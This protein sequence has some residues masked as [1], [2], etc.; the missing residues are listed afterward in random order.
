MS[1]EPV[2]FRPDPRRPLAA[3]AVRLTL[4]RFVEGWRALPGAARRRWFGTLGAGLVVS[5]AV[6]LGLDVWAM[7]L[8][9]AGRLAW[10]ADALRRIEA[11]SP[12]SFAQSLWGEAPGNAV[13]LIPLVLLVAAACAW[14]GRPLRA[15][16]VLAVFFLLDAVVLLG[17]WYWDRA[18]PDV[19]AGG[20]AAPGFHS[21]PSGHV[22]QT[23]STYGFLAW[24][25]MRASPSG[26]ER[27]L[28]VL[29]AVAVTAL[30]ALARLR[31]G[32]HWPSDIAAG[33]LVGGLWMVV[34]ATALARA[35][36]AGGR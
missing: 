4:R 17:W 32:T 25:W 1:T 28:A 22:S 9:R 34:V 10:E 29:C 30:V 3:E 8:E 13:L 35:E 36:A 16:S 6:M 5:W 27:V 15:L 21:F 7:R 12:L 14:S 19:I 33:A 20:I 31:L 2:R 11:R 24:L 23:L 18:R 26:V